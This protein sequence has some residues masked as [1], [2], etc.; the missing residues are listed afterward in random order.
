MRIDKSMGTWLIAAGLLWMGILTPRALQAQQ[1]AD[2]LS[3]AAANPV[4]A[5]ISVPFQYNADFGLGDYD[6]TRSVLNIQPVIPFA[7][8]KIITRTIIPVVGLPDI[9]SESGSFSTGLS[10]IMI[11]AFYVPESASS[12]MWAVGPVLEIP[13]GGADRGSKKWSGGPSALL[14]A[15]PG[16]WTLGV[17]ANQVWSFA[18]DS[19]RSAVSKGFVQYF[20]VRQLGNGWYVNSAPA[21]TANWKAPEGQKY[22]V[23]FGLG[24]GKIAFL[25]KLPVNTQ[26]GAF[27]NAVKPDIGPDWQLRFQVQFMLPTPG[28]G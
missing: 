18:G 7:G 8:G 5:M 21:I 16:P 23:P 22:V 13:T 27:Y 26:V 20:I 3:K 25:G 17:L 15:Q 14:M 28:S 11:T 4:A 10:D 1:T 9:S 12:V 24:A 19:D 6:R 2:E